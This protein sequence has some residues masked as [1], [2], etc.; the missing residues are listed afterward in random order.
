MIPV[1]KQLIYLPF[2]LHT[3]ILPR[4]VLEG[5]SKETPSLIITLKTVL[6]IDAGVV[7][8]IILSFKW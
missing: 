4:I 1:N 2:T 6:W 8:A 7:P 3:S 5:E